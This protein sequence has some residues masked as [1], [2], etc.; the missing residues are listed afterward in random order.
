LPCRCGIDISRPSKLPDHSV[1]PTPSFACSL[2]NQHVIDPELAASP[3]LE[4]GHNALWLANLPIP[5]NPP[6]R[7]STKVASKPPPLYKDREALCRKLGIAIDDA[8]A[9][10]D[11]RDWIEQQ[12]NRHGFFLRQ[13]YTL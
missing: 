13:Q 1:R 5:S 7:K 2:A 4:A 9:M 12:C 6:H 11:L 10:N 3:A 8:N